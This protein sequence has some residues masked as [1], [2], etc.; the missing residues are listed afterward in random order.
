MIIKYYSSAFIDSEV[1]VI[2]KEGLAGASPARQSFF[3]Y[4]ND[5]DFKVFSCDARHV[6]MKIYYVW[7]EEVSSPLNGHRFLKKIG[8]QQFLE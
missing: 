3:G 5:K 2:P 4:D 1:G 7:P 6:R 8:R